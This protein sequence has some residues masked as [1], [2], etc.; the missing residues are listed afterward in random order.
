MPNTDENAVS[1]A[2]NAAEEIRS[3]YHAVSWAKELGGAGI[4]PGT[5]K[6]R[7]ITASFPP[8][9]REASS[10]LLGQLSRKTILTI[11]DLDTIR[12][13]FGEKVALFALAAHIPL[14]E[15]EC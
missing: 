15:H 14:S 6:W 13:L 8:H 7:N 4:K 9:D 2:E 5:G 1:E 11:E 3:V 10:N 12:A